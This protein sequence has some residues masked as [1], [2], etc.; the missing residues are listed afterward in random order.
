MKALDTY[1]EKF[2]EYEEKRGK[3]VFTGEWNFLVELFDNIEEYFKKVDRDDVIAK[4]QGLKASKVK[5]KDWCPV[6]LE[7]MHSLHLEK[8][9]RIRYAGY[10][11]Q[12]G[13]SNIANCYMAAGADSM[14]RS[15][16][17]E[18]M[19]KAITKWGGS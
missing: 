2:K 15:N 13:R 11:K 4:L 3:K 10:D 6:K 19:S 9:M 17:A 5:V 1:T 8:A 16:V 14:K 18:D 12:S 7:G